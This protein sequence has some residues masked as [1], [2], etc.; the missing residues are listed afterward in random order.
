MFS[1]I[2]KQGVRSS[3]GFEVQFTGRWTAEYREGTRYLVVDIEGT[4]DGV[5]D[6]DSNA[7]GQWANSSI[8]NSP[9]DQ[10]RLHKN[11]VAALEFE[12]LTGI[13]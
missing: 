8:T 11:F 5:I 4:G 7:F 3:D 6:F 10:A 13:P 1:W 2:N 9:A 12:G